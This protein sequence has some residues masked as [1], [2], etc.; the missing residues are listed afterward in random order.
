MSFLEEEVVGSPESEQE[1]IKSVLGGNS[2]IGVQRLD[3]ARQFNQ[4]IAQGQVGGGEIGNKGGRGSVEFFSDLRNSI[5]SWDASARLVFLQGG[6]CDPN[7][8]GKLPHAHTPVH[9]FPLQ[10]GRKN[11]LHRQKDHLLGFSI[12]RWILSVNTR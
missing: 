5:A 6:K 3:F 8:I 2:G 1:Q 4:R 7:F 9:P 10:C 12:R 11:F